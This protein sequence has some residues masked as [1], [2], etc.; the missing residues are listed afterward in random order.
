MRYCIMELNIFDSAFIAS[1]N[2]ISFFDSVSF[3]SASANP[4]NHFAVIFKLQGSVWPKVFPFCLF[5][6]LVT[7]GVY[8]LLE[9]TGIDLTF[10]GG[11]GYTFISTVVSFFVISNLGS[12]YG[13]FWEVILARLSTR[14][15]CSR[16]AQRFIQRT[17]NPTAQMFGA[18]L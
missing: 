6:V 18:Q 2:S 9:H 13:R 12:T 17:T 10:N 16:R 7:A 4:R 3:F 5:N 14:R 11:L 8:F 15:T 1:R